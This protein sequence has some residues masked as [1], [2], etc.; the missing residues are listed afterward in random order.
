MVD[1][2]EVTDFVSVKAYGG[3]GLVTTIAEVF[4][5]VAL[6]NHERG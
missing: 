3:I 6:R 1:V 4:A 2:N 5:V